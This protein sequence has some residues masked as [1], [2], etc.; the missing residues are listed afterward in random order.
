MDTATALAWMR[1][2]A[3]AVTAHEAE[4]TALDA[5]IG[6]G[7]HGANLR[8][9]FAA[10]VVGAED[11]EADA[12]EPGPFLVQV[13]G[14]LISNV[15]GAAGPLYGTALRTTGKALS[16]PLADTAALAAALRTG[17][18]ALCRLGG[19]AVGDKTMVDAFDPAVAA[20][21]S[22]DDADLRHAALLAADAAEEGMRATIPLRAKKGRASYLGERSIGHQDPGATSTALLFRALAETLTR[23]PS[24]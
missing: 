16:G 9:G 21:Q 15:G 10:V 18:D 12:V 7:D 4:L 19:A 2:V 14:T 22:A 17:L 24:A 6:D 5:A 1:A 20:F 13:G 3:E 8:R 23:P 11:L